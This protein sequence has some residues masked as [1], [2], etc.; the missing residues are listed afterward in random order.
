MN[1]QPKAIDRLKQTWNENP[2][3]VISTGALA[4][5]AAA[6]L[7]DSVSSVQSRRAYSKQINRKKR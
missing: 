4:V 3:L 7:L 2:L 5:T 6:K 1:N